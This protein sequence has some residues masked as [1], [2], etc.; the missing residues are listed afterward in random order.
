MD[1]NPELREA[2]CE[3]FGLRSRTRDDDALAHVLCSVGA[4]GGEDG[5]GV[6]R[7]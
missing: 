5:G 6:L 1:P 2:R 4:A 7:F 3:C